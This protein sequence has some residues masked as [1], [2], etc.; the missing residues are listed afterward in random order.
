MTWILPVK[1]ET[2]KVVFLKF[3]KIITNYC[4]LPLQGSLKVYCVLYDWKNLN[5][6][7]PGEMKGRCWQRLLGPEK[8]NCQR[9][10][11]IIFTQFHQKHWHRPSRKTYF[12]IFRH[13]A[14]FS[15][16]FIPSSILLNKSTLQNTSFWDFK[17]IRI[18]DTMPLI[19][20]DILI[21][22]ILGGVENFNWSFKV[23]WGS[24]LLILT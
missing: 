19:I 1:I 4:P 6:T 3:A 10:K 23:K 12:W 11:K 5:K 7:R 17:S 9:M 22:G 18:W 16:S 24:C 20:L 8:I 2:I 14:V 13:R 15:A 21:F